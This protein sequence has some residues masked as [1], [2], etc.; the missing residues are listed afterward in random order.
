VRDAVVFPADDGAL[1][2][3]VAEDDTGPEFALT[4]ASEATTE[5]SE[6]RVA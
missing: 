2:S 4:E 5:A 3:R 6:L 1:G